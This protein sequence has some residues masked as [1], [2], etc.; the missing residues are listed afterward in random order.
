M[1][2]NIEYYK[3][4]G[5]VKFGMSPVEVEDLLGQ[6]EDSDSSRIFARKEFRDL[7]YPIIYYEKSGVAEIMF[8]KE[9]S[10]VKIFD[11]DDIFAQN[12]I[13]VLQA[14]SLRDKDL[15]ETVGII[16]SVELGIALT[17]FHDQDEDQ[18]TVA[19][20]RRNLWNSRLD[21]SSKISF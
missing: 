8:T 12:P 7:S 21:D 3:G 1:L 5:L 15:R 4:V 2:W 17:G 11:I 6:P 19:A 14:V 13:N 20:F 18:K 16:V 9:A 10:N